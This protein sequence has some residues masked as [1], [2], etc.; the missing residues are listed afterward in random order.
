MLPC[1][2]VVPCETSVADDALLA[3]VRRPERVVWDDTPVSF[4]ARPR[5]VAVGS[6]HKFPSLLS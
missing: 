5:L 6:R 1:S 3:G 2:T 4:V